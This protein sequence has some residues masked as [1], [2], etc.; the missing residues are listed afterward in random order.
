L[1]SSR[2]RREGGGES[3]RD[4]VLDDEPREPDEVLGGGLEGRDE[5]GGVRG[6]TVGRGVVEVGGVTR[7]VG[8]GDPGVGVTRVDGGAGV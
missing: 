8:R 6:V 3:L 2:D 4:D 5:G 1:P 7:V